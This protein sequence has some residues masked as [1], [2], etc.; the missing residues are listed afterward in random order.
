MA[1][2]WFTQKQDVDGAYYYVGEYKPDEENDPYVLVSGDAFD[3]FGFKVLRP[4]ERNTGRVIQMHNIA[5]R[6]LDYDAS[7]DVWRCVKADWR[8]WGHVVQTQVV[9]RWQK[10]KHRLRL[11]LH[12]WGIRKDPCVHIEV[13]PF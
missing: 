9:H 13:R 6:L 10:L 5:L 4:I 12:V 3:D 1:D 7:R 8:S 2:V 11:T